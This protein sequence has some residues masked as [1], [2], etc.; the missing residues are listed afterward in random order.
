MSAG[1]TCLTLILLLAGWLTG[2][3]GFKFD[4]RTYCDLPYCGENNVVCLKSNHS[5]QCNPM[6]KFVSLRHHKREILAA[7]NRFRNK[8]ATGL[9]R[10]LLP[11]GR[12]A[13]MDWSEE[14]EYFAKADLLTCIPL[15]RPCMTSPSIPNI[16]SIF[17]SEGY[18]GKEMQ[19]QDVVLKIMS[20]WFK[21]GQYVT[22]AQSVY[23]E[24][25]QDSRSTYRAVLLITER[26]TAVGCAAMKY[27]E[28]RVHYFYLSCCFST[29][30]MKRT[31]IYQ[32]AL[33]AGTLCKR[34]D[35]QYKNLCAI[36]E[37]YP[38]NNQTYS[39]QYI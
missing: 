12:M 32:S 11:A 16:G 29:V 27:T 30:G 2:V 33:K 7:L 36:G 22:R 20:T 5:F 37:Q 10:Y 17:D 28:D 24:E 4:A 1:C 14:L 15:P 3:S 35:I 26:N 9:T 23:L 38:V 31:A 8:A 13:R 19:N 25:R 6:A 39:D 18:T 34:R 21:E